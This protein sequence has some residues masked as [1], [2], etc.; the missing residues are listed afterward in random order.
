MSHN[1]RK[2]ARVGE[3][4]NEISTSLFHDIIFNVI[5][6]KNVYEP[7]SNTN[8][9]RKNLNTVSNTDLYR[10]KS[11]L[12]LRIEKNFSSQDTN[13][14]INTSMIITKRNYV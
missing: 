7:I 8:L 11:D 10:D 12:C 4:P 3:L 13:C 2:L 5:R 6:R 1:R 14:E 9:T